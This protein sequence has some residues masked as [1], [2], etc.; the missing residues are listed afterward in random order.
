MSTICGIFIMHLEFYVNDICTTM[1]QCRICHLHVT[2][3]ST[4]ANVS[5]NL[6]PNM[7]R[8][9]WLQEM[10]LVNEM[11]WDC[12]QSPKEKRLWGTIKSKVVYSTERKLEFCPV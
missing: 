12:N 7:R 9:V 6:R 11:T 10:G 8:H 1:F 4:E 5:Q 3:D 2:D